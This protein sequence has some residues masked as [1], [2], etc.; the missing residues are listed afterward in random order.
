MIHYYNVV[1]QELIIRGCYA[2]FD[3]GP[4]LSVG[5]ARRNIGKR[6]RELRRVIYQRLRAQ[7]RELT[8]KYTE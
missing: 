5:D 4:L 1:T 7:S 6:H 8:C 3:N 2:H